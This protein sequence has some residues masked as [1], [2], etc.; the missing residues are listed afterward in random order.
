LAHHTAFPGYVYGGLIASL[1]DCHSIG[2]AIAAAYAAEGR[3]PDSE[4]AIT[5]VTGTLHVRFVRPTPMDTDLELRAQVKTQEGKK[6]VIDCVLMADGKACA[7]AEVIAI[8]APW[9]LDH[10]S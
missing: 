5:F 7:Q 8:R 3:E 9:N 6:S 10:H 2:T 1:M 4:P